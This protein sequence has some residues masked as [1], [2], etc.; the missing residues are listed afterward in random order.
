[1]KLHDKNSVI[2]TITFFRRT[3]RHPFPGVRAEAVNGRS[4]LPETQ[5][6]SFR[7]PFSSTHFQAHGR[8]K[9]LTGKSIN[10][11]LAWRFI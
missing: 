4:L 10:A 3:A 8:E 1:M 9:R 6:A 2:D 7:L 11:S 5:T